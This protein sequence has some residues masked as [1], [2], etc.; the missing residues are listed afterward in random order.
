M[1]F[2]QKLRCVNYK[3]IDAFL[4]GF[5]PFPIFY[6]PASVFTPVSCTHRFPFSHM[7]SPIWRPLEYGSSFLIL[8]P[9]AILSNPVVLNQGQCCPSLPGRHPQC[10]ETFWLSHLEVCTGIQWVE[11]RDAA[12]HPAQEP[13]SPTENDL[14]NMLTVLRLRSLAV[15][16]D[17][18]LSFPPVHG[19]EFH[20]AVLY[21]S[22]LKK[23][24]SPHSLPTSWALPSPFRSSLQHTSPSLHPM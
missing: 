22:S 9:S 2:F 20:R 15:S 4:V 13:P 17:C 21:F 6:T 11:V 5:C 12:R 7:D 8:V 10:L 23:K 16:N 1:S 19:L 24:R 14:A 3:G 18:L